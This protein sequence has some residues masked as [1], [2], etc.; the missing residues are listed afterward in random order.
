MRKKNSLACGRAGF[1]NDTLN[2]RFACKMKSAVKRRQP[3]SGKGWGLQNIFWLLLLITFGSPVTA[4]QNGANACLRS[5]Q[6]A[7]AKQEYDA[8]IAQLQRCIEQ[9]PA[10]V[11]L[12]LLFGQAHEGKQEY[13]SA[14]DSYRQAMALQP[15][16]AQ[17]HYFLGV[18]LYKQNILPEA[19]EALNQ[20]VWLA[21]EDSDKHYM[22]ATVLYRLELYGDALAAYRRTLALRPCHAGALNNIGTI[23]RIQEKAAEAEA[24]YHQ[25]IACDS[26]YF[27][28]RRNLGFLYLKQQQPEK[29]LAPLQASL[30]LSAE[31]PQSHYYLANALFDL[32]RYREAIPHYLATTEGRPGFAPAYH[33]LGLCYQKTLEWS[34]GLHALQQAVRFAPGDALYRKRLADA[35]LRME[36]IDEA[37]AEYLV[38]LAIDSAMAAAHFRLGDI[39][40]KKE[41]YLMALDRYDIASRFGFDSSKVHFKKGVALFLLARYDEAIVELRQVAQGAPEHP[42]A[43]FH[44][45]MVY[46]TRDSLNAA[47]N[48]LARA[49]RLDSNFADIPYQLGLAYSRMGSYQ[50]AAQTLQKAIALNP[51]HSGAHYNLARAWRHLGEPEKAEAEMKVFARLSELEREINRYQRLITSLP[52]SAGLY[53]ELARR[54][55]EVQDYSAALHTIR[56][57]LKLDPENQSAKE[58]LSKIVAALT[59]QKLLEVE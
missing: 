31:D 17:A 36:I 26:T 32:G 29:A 5:G 2:K 35:Y 45:G 34:K 33:N 19:L 11:E 41:N 12:H 24:A 51:N 37:A 53:Y 14:E 52:D 21:P 6:Q 3:T 15:N 49:D 57:G 56:L 39:Y 28:V 40:K 58:L 55:Y 27:L 13:M 7:I 43:L 25:A 44:L 30:Q 42:R 46:L 9:Q 54:Q 1:Q 59:R 22:R 16:N 20:A 47:V 10:N 18:V 50:H 23:L 4:Q 8:A 48:V 38:A